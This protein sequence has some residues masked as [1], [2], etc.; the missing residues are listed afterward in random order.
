MLLD[1]GVQKRLGR[2]K[3]EMVKGRLSYKSIFV[4]QIKTAG[5]EIVEQR[6]TEGTGRGKIRARLAEEEE[7]VEVSVERQ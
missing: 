7:K 2:C 1:D 4:C 5:N 6:I 3:G